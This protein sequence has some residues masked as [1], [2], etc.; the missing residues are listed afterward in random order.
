MSGSGIDEVV[1]EFRQFLE[2]AVDSVGAGQSIIL[3]IS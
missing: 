1:A 2:N 3:E